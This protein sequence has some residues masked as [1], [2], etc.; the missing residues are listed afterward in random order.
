MASSSKGKE[1][2]SLGP[3]FY[4][5]LNGLREEFDLQANATPRNSS[6][7][8]RFNFYLGGLEFEFELMAQEIESLQKERDEDREKGIFFSI[9]LI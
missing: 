2:K 9:T 4:D 7:P 5:Y 6:R 8:S 3:R 1:K